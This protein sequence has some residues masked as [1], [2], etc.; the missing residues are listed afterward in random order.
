MTFNYNLRRLRKLNNW[1]QTELASLIG[2]DQRTIS[3]WENSICEPD[4]G[5]LIKLKQIFKITI[6]DLVED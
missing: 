4:I 3:A 6:D 1:N 5:T 2:V